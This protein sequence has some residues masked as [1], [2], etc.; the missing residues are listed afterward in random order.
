MDNQT[1]I[2]PNNCFRS[3]DHGF[4]DRNSG[5][6]CNPGYYSDNCGDSIPELYPSLWWTVRSINILLYLVV[7]GA[8][9]YIIIKKYKGTETDIYFHTDRIILICCTF[10]SFFQLL[11]GILDPDGFDDWN[12]P[13]SLRYFLNFNLFALVSTI[14]SFLLVRW[15]EVYNKSLEYLSR[16]EMYIKI[17]RNYNPDVSIEGLMKEIDHINVK[18]RIPF[19]VI[20]VLEYILSSFLAICYPYIEIELLYLFIYIWLTSL[21]IIY[22]LLIVLSY[23]YGRKMLLVIHSSDKLSRRMKRASRLVLFIGIIYIIVFLS[24]FS[25]FLHSSPTTYFVENILYNLIILL[26]IVFIL[27]SSYLSH[28]RAKESSSLAITTTNSSKT[29]TINLDSI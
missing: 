19:V 3:R 16:Q 7:T 2:C 15:L 4:C 22:I 12:I 6:I 23:I 8:C 11:L 27:S 25:V 21:A 10:L 28:L 18:Y 20:N 13:A 5:C 26:T 29:M 9:I 24:I 14:F 1:D 17:N